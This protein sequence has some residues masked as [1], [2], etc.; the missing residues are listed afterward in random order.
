MAFFAGHPW[1]LGDAASQ[2]KRLGAYAEITW[3]IW[4]AGC[5]GTETRS[6]RISHVDATN[7]TRKLYETMFSYG[8][9]TSEYKKLSAGVTNE[10]E[11]GEKFKTIRLKFKSLNDKNFGSY[12][13]EN[14][15]GN[16]QPG[17]VNKVVDGQWGEWG[18]YGDCSKTC[19]T[20][21]CRVFGVFICNKNFQKPSSYHPIYR[22]GSAFINYTKS[23]TESGPACY[24]GFST[25]LY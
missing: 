24:I 3:Q 2:N 22:H 4:F 23:S 16:S 17:Q 5:D 25:Y 8:T 13:V 7:V 14:D 15:K 6:Y 11:S 20:G 19:I 12:L 21:N 18:P 9:L 1:L 10:E